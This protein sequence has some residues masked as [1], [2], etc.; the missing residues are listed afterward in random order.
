MKERTFFRISAVSGFRFPFDP[1]FLAVQK[2][3]TKIFIT[4]IDDEVVDLTTFTFSLAR[5]TNFDV[6]LLMDA[7]MVT[8]EQSIEASF[9]TQ[10]NKKIRSVHV[11]Q[12]N[13]RRN[14]LNL[15]SPNFY[16]APY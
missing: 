11:F 14:V 8:E 12:C 7:I 10:I 2:L 4:F 16:F 9:C 1:G 6:L 5:R 15:R 13:I 3:C